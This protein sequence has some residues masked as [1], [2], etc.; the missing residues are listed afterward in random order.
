MAGTDMYIL[1]ELLGH[2]VFAMTARYSHLSP[3]TLR[4]ATKNIE[5]AVETA[6]KETGKNGQV[7]N[8]PQYKPLL[9][10]FI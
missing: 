3:D 1:K 9:Y 6:K 7:V 5:K 2:Q 8:L 4:A 10:T